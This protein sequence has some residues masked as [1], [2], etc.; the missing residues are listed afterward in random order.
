MRQGM[1]TPKD[2]V[3]ATMKNAS[4]IIVMILDDVGR[5]LQEIHSQQVK[6]GRPG[7]TKLDAD[8][9]KHKDEFAAADAADVQH[10]GRDRCTLG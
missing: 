1:E 8:L 10:R 4:A 3:D 2:A 7:D 6:G 9:E 5:R